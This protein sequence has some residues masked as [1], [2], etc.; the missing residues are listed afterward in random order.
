MEFSYRTD[1][2]PINIYAL[3]RINGTEKWECMER[4]MSCRTKHIKIKKWELEGLTALCEHLASLI[5][6]VSMLEFYYSFTLPRLGKEFDLL[7]IGANSVL[8]IE[9]K[10]KEVSDESIRKQLLLNHYYLS[11]LNKTPYFFTYISEANRLVRLSHSGRLLDTDWDT[12]VSVLQ[13]QNECYEGDIE[14]LFRENEFLISPLTNSGRFLRKEYFLTSQQR[15]IKSKI[16]DDIRC[17]GQALHTGFTGLPGTGKTLLLYDLAVELSANKNVCLFH[18]GAHAG[19]L[20]QLNIRLKRIS[21]YYCRKGEDVKI[22]GD[23]AALFID[24]GHRIDEK[25]LN[26]ILS[27]AQNASIPLIIS[28]DSEAPIA[29]KE[30]KKLSTDLIEGIPG[31]VRYRLTN[32]IRL[33]KE[34]SE[35]INRIMYL[36]CKHQKKLYPSALLLYAKDTEEA[37]RLKTGFIREGYTYIRD[38]LIDNS[39][40]AGDDVINIRQATSREFDKVIMM[41]DRS[42]YYDDNGYL[43]STEPGDGKIRHL[44]HGL[45]RAKKNIAVIVQ[46]NESVFDTILALMQN[47]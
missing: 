35:F 2:K 24:E 21:F 42:F 15:D 20:E 25:T 14:D 39:A 46:G 47:P 10:S 19:E 27:F 12:L 43:R 40:I 45:N 34:L 38:L 30:Q 22:E 1:M 33:N 3:T 44:Y 29:L 6:D 32:R 26:T 7:R 5:S 36:N 13:G 8:N 9:L 16:L 23:Y 41:L 18:F 31:F 17:H 4:Q 37:D 11:M 28:Y